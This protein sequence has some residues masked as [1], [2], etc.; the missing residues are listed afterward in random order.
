MR[1]GDCFGHG[2][3]SIAISQCIQERN[4]IVDL[5]VCPDRSFPGVVCQGFI[6]MINV[7]LKF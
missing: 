4:D 1:S 5:I 6:N 7:D 2:V 3:E